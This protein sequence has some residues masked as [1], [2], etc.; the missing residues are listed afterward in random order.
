L[1]ARSHF[2]RTLPL[3]LVSMAFA[4]IHRW[5]APPATGVYAMHFDASLPETLSTYWEWTVGTAWLS[6]FLPPALPDWPE[7]VRAFVALVNLAPLAYLAAAAGQRRRLPAFGL[8]WFVIVLSPLLPLRDHVAEYYVFVPSIGVAWL[9][10]D[11][12]VQA[13]R[14]GWLWQAAVA[15]WLVG[16]VAG[17][18][19]AG[20]QHA[21]WLV[22]LGDRARGLVRSVARIEASRPGR[23]IL[24]HGA[25]GAL[26]WT[27]MTN[28]AYELVDAEVLLTPESLADFARHPDW[29]DPSLYVLSAEETRR[30]LLEQRALV[31][32][33]RGAQLVEI[34]A[35]YARRLQQDP[36]A[37]D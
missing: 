15:V 26:L 37:S 13:R 1:F 21:R 30:A 2:K 14:A 4:L 33:V 16:Y 20:Q 29:E 8:A 3:F 10:A 11:A 36:D 27:T 5:A 19:P 7:L 34:T 18:V 31:Y 6:A 12:F 28:R 32:E 22:G 9:A 23:T 24:L 17:L 25:D 35:A